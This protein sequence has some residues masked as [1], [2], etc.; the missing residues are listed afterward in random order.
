VIIFYSVSFLSKIKKQIEF[1][2][3][4]KQN[5]TETSSNRLVSVQFGFLGQ[6]RF[7]PAW[8]GFFSLAWFLAGLARFIFWF[9]FSFGSF[10]FGFFGFR[11]IKPKPNWPVFLKF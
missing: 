6:N 9:F 5:R 4:K 11:L 10:R 3:L 7:K 8:L 2:F 1:F